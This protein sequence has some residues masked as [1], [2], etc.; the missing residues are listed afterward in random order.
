MWKRV[1]RDSSSARRFT[2]T[3]LSVSHSASTVRAPATVAV[4]LSAT[5]EVAAPSAR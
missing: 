5:S 1:R 3:R 4:R 2:A